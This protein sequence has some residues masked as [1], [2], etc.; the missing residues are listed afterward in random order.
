MLLKE[1]NLDEAL[2][3]QKRSGMREGIRK[4]QE[5]TARNMKAKGLDLHLIAEITGLTFDEV[6]NV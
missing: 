6:L 3:V 2:M 5:D 1:W 4:N